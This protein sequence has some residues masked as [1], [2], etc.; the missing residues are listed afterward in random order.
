MVRFRLM[1][2]RYLR[3][4][5]SGSLPSFS[6]SCSKPMRTNTSLHSR[7]TQKLPSENSAILRVRG[8]SS[9]STMCS[10]ACAAMR[11]GHSAAELRARLPRAPAAFDLVLSSGSFNNATNPGTAERRSA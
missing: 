2:A 8:S 10:N 5:G 9:A 6:I 1:R 3:T 11:S 4:V 7:C